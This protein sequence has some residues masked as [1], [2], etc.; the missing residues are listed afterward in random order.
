MERGSEQTG[1][2]AEQTE[3]GAEQMER[4]AEQTGRGAEHTEWQQ[5][6]TERDMGQAEREESIIVLE[7]IVNLILSKQSEGSHVNEQTLAKAL[8][9][10]CVQW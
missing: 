1:R 5:Q 4:G 10:L 8:K 9:E 7:R 2:G 3:Q 6:F